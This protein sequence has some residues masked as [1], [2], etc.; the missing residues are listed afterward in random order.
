MFQKLLQRL[1]IF[2]LALII[3]VF[4]AL[5]FILDLKID[6]KGLHLGSVAVENLFS[7]ENVTLRYEKES[8]FL[9]IETAVIH[10]KVLE[11]FSTE[12]NFENVGL[13]I[14]NG[15]FKGAATVNFQLDCPPHQP[16]QLLID[17]RAR[18]S[19]DQNREIE[20]GFDKLSIEE[21]KGWISEFYFHPSFDWIGKGTLD[22]SIRLDLDSRRITD[23]ELYLHH[24]QG[25]DPESGA[26]ISVERIK[27][28]RDQK[29][30]VLNGSIRIV[31]QK[32][33][34]D[35]GIENLNGILRWTEDNGVFFNLDGLL[36][37][38]LD[39]FPIF[40]EGCRGEKTIFEADASILL[41]QGHNLNRYFHISLENPNEGLFVL[42]GLFDHVVESEL[43]ALNQLFKP[44]VPE[45]EIV[46]I[47]DLKA[48]FEIKGI[49]E[50]GHLTSITAENIEGD[51]EV[52]FYG[53]NKVSLALKASYTDSGVLRCKILDKAS[54]GDIDL[55]IKDEKAHIRGICLSDGLLNSLLT[56]FRDG[57]TLKGVADVTGQIEKNNTRLHL[58]S[59]DLTFIDEHVEFI[60]TEKPLDADFM[61]L[62]DQNLQGV[63]DCREGIL[64]IHHLFDNPLVFTGLKSRI[65]IWNEEVYLDEVRTVYKETNL[66]GKLCLRPISTGG[67]RL[68]LD[69]E[70]ARG[71]I[72]NFTDW[73]HPLECFI[74]GEV[75]LDEKG[76]NLEADLVE[77]GD[78]NYEIDLKIIG[79]HLGGK[80][81]PYTGLDLE[82]FHSTR[83]KNT[84][85]DVRLAET[86]MDWIRFSGKIEDRFIIF[87]PLKNHFFQKPFK[88]IV[89]GEGEAGISFELNAEEIQSLFTLIR[90]NPPQPLS[91]M[92]CFLGFRDFAEFLAGTLKIDGQEW[93]F[94][95]ERGNFILKKG[96]CTFEGYSINYEDIHL[97]LK[98]LKLSSPAVQILGPHMDLQFCLKQGL[99]AFENS[100]LHGVSFR[101]L[102]P[103]ETY[104][105]GFYL[106][107]TK[108]IFLIDERHRLQLSSA[109]M[110][111]FHQ[112][113]LF[114]SSKLEFDA[115][116]FLKVK[117]VLSGWL[118]GEISRENPFID[119]KM[120]PFSGVY[121]GQN[122][123]IHQLGCSLYPDGLK[124]QFE[125]MLDHLHF[126][127]TVATI[128]KV[129][130][131]YNCKLETDLGKAFIDV[132]MDPDLGWVVHGS[133]GDLLGLIWNCAPYKNLKD[134]EKL[135]LIGSWTLDPALFAAGLVTFKIPFDLPYKIEKPIRLNGVLEIPRDNPTR[136]GF[137]GN[138]FGRH[139]K[140]EGINCRNLF[141][142]I[143][144]EEGLVNLTKLHMIDPSYELEIDAIDLLLEQKELL[145]EGLRLLDFRPSLCKTNSLTKVEDPFTIKEMVIPS[146]SV[147]YNQGLHCKG[148]GELYFLNRED[149]KK[150]L[151][152]L[153]WDIL[154]VLGLDPS[155]LV[156]TSGHLE[157][158]FDKDKIILER[159]K[160]SYSEKYRSSFFLDP[161]NLSYI[162]LDGTLFI[163]LRMKQSVILKLA[164]PFIIAVDGTF[165]NP[166]F[167]LK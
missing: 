111:L 164:E 153:P 70:T 93:I 89:G 107:W 8:L 92:E 50:N 96:S 48:K 132:Q 3:G 36:R 159:L 136:C 85:F 138:L 55:T 108:G 87:D 35:F 115:E 127:S 25:G 11:Y 118:K 141:S 134:K 148:K 13:S 145:I 56:P 30:D 60:L 80:D 88:Q 2:L 158:S 120:T 104:I 82:L 4:S 1:C 9:D 65:S 105:D 135:S 152:D 68:N 94:A 34:Y 18:I 140:I 121:G 119:L 45:L 133:K 12:K 147:Q 144:Y 117:T 26:H 43:H 53:Q 57:W 38:G 97:D 129:F 10:K 77:G 123:Q 95:K 61:I 112:K 142:E 39:S 67:R 126:K 163:R 37:Q 101:T 41:N 102:E 54:K 64:K 72:I 84:T 51:L 91:H 58:T 151:S 40:L 33:G 116:P 139:M 98:N 154:S 74:E 21:L 110:D 15:F 17:Q 6:A 24:M 100:N 106:D 44:N 165:Q 160:R 150:N 86:S 32:E 161:K 156:P 122:I 90:V 128:D 16:M 42:K 47:E 22:G 5:G 19:F 130:E 52:S 103:V 49:W 143:R 146:L 63:L 14:K 155:L 31:E 114:K 157:F 125:G 75:E 81:D 69:V 79:A 76:F 131:R 27:I 28:R 78:L 137:K 109:K 113:F 7:F 20:I 167:K 62:E 149:R 66:T 124:A 71:P 29:L 83:T 73:I 46:Y 162:G 166:S 99:L 59:T 23:G